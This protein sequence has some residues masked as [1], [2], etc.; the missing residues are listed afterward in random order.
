L[1]KSTRIAIL[2]HQFNDPAG[3]ESFFTAGIGGQRGQHGQ[4]LSHPPT[5]GQDSY[6][7]TQRLAGKATQFWFYWVDRN[8][9]VRVLV[10]GPDGTITEAAATEF[11]QHQA[12]I[13]QQA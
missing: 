2:I 4:D 9:L 12:R 6:S 7:F 10:S 8:I 3:A 5:L 13:V 1:D 11:A